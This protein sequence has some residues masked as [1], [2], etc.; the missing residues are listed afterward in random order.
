M[1]EI[2]AHEPDVTAAVIVDDLFGR[3]SV[4]LWLSENAESMRIS[5]MIQERLALA[6]IQYW[7]REIRVSEVRSPDL[8]QDR[9]YQ[10]AWREGA[11]VDDSDRLRLNDRH[12]H[13]TGW[14][15]DTDSN[16]LWPLDEGP[17]IIA[18]HGFKGGAGRTTLLAGY[19]LSWA[20]RRASVAVV[21]MDL[22]APGLGTL[23]AA[24][25]EG[26]TAPWGVL[27]YLLEAPGTLDLG[28][29]FHICARHEV[30][31]EGRVEVF[32]AGTLDDVYL[33]K[34]ARVDLDVRRDVRQHPLAALLHAIRTRNPKLIL[35]DGRAGLSPA[36]GLLL[37]G[38]AHFHVLISTSNPQNLLGL[39]RVVRHLGFEQ[40]RRDRAQ[41]EC[42]VVQA[43]VP[44]SSE[45]ARSARED[46]AVRVEDI[47]RDGYY[48]REPT[49]DDRTWSLR[50]L[51]SEIAP[52]VPV[53]IT[54]RGRLAHFSNIDEI[55]EL[56]VS[57]PEHEHLHRRI[58]ERLGIKSDSNQYEAP[59]GEPE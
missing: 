44:D 31:G 28:D 41:A 40:A 36:A 6:C 4:I 29:Y 23:L 45:A 20:R 33:T 5:V 51:E 58:D 13:H 15:T 49:E 57:D 56:L 54:Y 37:S 8:E 12:R 34:L 19:A 1:V 46:F 53:P 7:T 50:D 14:F 22:D 9:L 59:L 25:R 21:D 3:I 47:F 43:M 2:L 39:E 27:D 52:H 11:T 48:T 32:P 35:L 38:I 55:A 26:T 42:L 30:T 16:R 24:D 17:P 10:T 18:F